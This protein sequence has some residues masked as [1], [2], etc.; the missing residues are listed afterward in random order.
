MI[1]ALSD[2]I[3]YHER[4]LRIFLH[5]ADPDEDLKKKL[6]EMWAAASSRVRRSADAGAFI[7][8]ESAAIALRDFIRLDDPTIE[9]PMEGIEVQLMG[10]RKCLEAVVACSRKDLS[11]KR[12]PWK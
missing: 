12:F 10:A 11:L 3:D 7:F 8:S 4:H 5:Q 2:L 1:E 6:Q 9:D